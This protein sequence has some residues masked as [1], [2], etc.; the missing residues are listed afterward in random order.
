VPE[1]ISCPSCHAVLPVPEPSDGKAIACP[2]CLAIVEVPMP[3]E[4]EPGAVMTAELLPLP[5]DRRRVR[6]ELDTGEAEPPELSDEPLPE[7][8]GMPA[9]PARKKRK[10]KAKKKRWFG[11][12]PRVTIGS[13]DWKFILF[14]SVPAAGLLA[15]GIGIY[16]ALR[17]LDPPTIP[18][19]DWVT[20]EV[21]ER[22]QAGLPGKTVKAR[23][24]RLGGYMDVQIC[25][26]TDRSL[27]LVG[28]T[29]DVLPAEKLARPP[30]KVLD[31][32]CDAVLRGLEGRGWKETHRTPTPVGLHEGRQLVIVVN[33]PRRRAPERRIPGGYL[34]GQE[35]FL[36]EPQM[37]W[38][39]GDWGKV[40]ARFYL[41]YGR[42]FVILG[43]GQ[44][45]E[46]RQDNVKRLFD[47]FVILDPAANPAEPTRSAP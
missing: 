46:S 32:T 36:S 6:A 20:V 25:E 43:G 13:L 28:Y 12:L 39:V 29:P 10:G 9:D 1:T 42:I 5:T 35:D 27:Y 41:A 8:P 18:A 4:P 7:R 24:G 3:P 47:S 14:L 33:N 37:A 19:E 31:E 40:I 11:W 21:P 34:T 15:V 30:N 23:C 26:P 17:V 44:G 2:H 45:F 38:A 16:F 22:Y